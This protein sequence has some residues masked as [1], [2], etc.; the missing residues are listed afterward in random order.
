MC[1]LLKQA[2]GRPCAASALCK[3]IRWTVCVP[4]LRSCRCAL[5]SLAWKVPGPLQGCALVTTAAQAHHLQATCNLLGSFTHTLSHVRERE[6][7]GRRPCWEFTAP[8][9]LVKG[10]DLAGL[11]PLSLCLRVLG[12]RPFR[13]SLHMPLH[14]RLHLPEHPGGKSQ[15]HC[16]SGA[17][18]LEEMRSSW[19]GKER[20]CERQESLSAPNFR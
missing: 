2:S 14:S 6:R 12:T 9:L 5:V 19:R 7:K 1:G 17:S 11:K 8:R 4:P 3:R 13:L 10:S 18:L 15:A 20:A 16:H